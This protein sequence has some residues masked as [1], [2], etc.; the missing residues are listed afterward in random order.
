MTSEEMVMEMKM[1]MMT[2]AEKDGEENR[3]TKEREE[4]S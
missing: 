4:R 2:R 1:K 3:R